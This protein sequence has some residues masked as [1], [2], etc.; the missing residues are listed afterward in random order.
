MPISYQKLLKKFKEKNIT[1][2]TIKKEKI[3]GQA[4]WK[5]IHENGHID[6]RT[7]ETLCEYFNCQPG[8]IIEYIPKKKK[9]SAYQEC[10]ESHLKALEEMDAMTEKETQF[11]L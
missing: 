6:T 7:I 1:S 11:P 10:L 3:I 4:T 5:K 2:Y 9:S 8:D